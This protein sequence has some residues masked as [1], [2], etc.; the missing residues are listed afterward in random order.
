MHHGPA[1]YLFSSNQLSRVIGQGDTIPRQPL[2]AF[3]IASAIGAGDTVLIGDSTFPGGA[4]AYSATAANGAAPAIRNLAMHVGEPIGADGV[5]DF[6]W[7]FAMNHPEQVAASIVSSD[8]GGTLL[9]NNSS[10]VKV[11]VDSSPGTPIDPSGGIPT[12]VINNLGEIAFNAFDPNSFTSGI[13][14]NSGGQNRLLVSASAPAPGGGTFG[15]FSSLALNSLDQLAFIAQP[16]SSAAGVFL[17]SNGAVTPLATDGTP[18]PG[19]GNF[20]LFF[21][22]PHFGPVI[23]D[24]G[25]VAFASFLTGTPGGFFGSGGI[26]LFKNGALSRIVGPNDPS[27]DGGV[28]L[29][30]DS[31]S[32]NS[33]GD[34]TFFA[35]TSAFGFGAFVYSGGKITQVAVAGDSVDGVALGLVEQ[36]VIN[37]SRHVAFTA[38]LLNGQNAVFAAAAPYDA[39][40]ASGDWITPT[41]GTPPP[42]QYIKQARANND[43][44][45]SKRGK[46]HS[47]AGVK[48]INP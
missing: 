7:G 22:F 17:S 1:L 13:F 28:F 32:I 42:P 19:G 23:D 4:G 2:F 43:L 33:S 47:G 30:A 45:Q 40:L 35:E 25:D 12:P 37:N 10:A 41:H 18:A 9:L 24:G 36:P 16:S 5:V 6:L 46:P 3:P 44:L 39:S 20:Q 31:P 27:P 21:G 29:C 14:L 15:N 26:F 34:V 8:A 11:L 38:T 48:V